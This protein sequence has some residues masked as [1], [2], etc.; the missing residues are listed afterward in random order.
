MDQAER[1]SELKD[2]WPHAPIREFSI[3]QILPEKI[4]SLGQVEEI[5]DSIR[6]EWSLGFNPISNVIS[7]LETQGILII[8][9]DAGSQHDFD[10]L[11][12][13]IGNQ[14]IIVCID[15]DDGARQRFTLA[16]ELGHLLLQNRIG[17]DMDEENVCN[18]FAGAL[19]LPSSIVQEHFGK[20][21]NTLEFQELYYLKHRFGISMQA[22]LRR[23]ADLSIISQNTYTSMMIEFSKRG[24]RKSEPEKPYPKEGTQ[25]FRS[26][27]FRA[28]GEGL[29]GE[30]K[31]AELLKEPLMQFH[32]ER[33]LELFHA[34]SHQ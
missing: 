9:T 13:K 28:L 24:W 2:L 8:I 21:R 31:A 25:V 26:L 4:C 14:P 3:P 18:R 17:A 29:I 33:S 22:C 1:W 32:R 5:A 27:V 16:H 19:L 15:Y 10:G 30:S 12:T 23:A 34:A 20:K 11:Q 6:K 7:M